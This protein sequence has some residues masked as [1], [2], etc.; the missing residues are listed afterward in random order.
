MCFTLVEKASKGRWNWRMWR[1]WQQKLQ[2]PTFDFS[3][4]SADAEIKRRAPGGPDWKMIP[5]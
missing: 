4:R 1:R 2:K 5:A 3:I